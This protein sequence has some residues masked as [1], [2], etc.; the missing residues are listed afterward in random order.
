VTFLVGI[1][2][3]ALD[4]S[5]VGVLPFMV[6]G[7]TGARRARADRQPGLLAALAAGAAAAQPLA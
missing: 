1:T 5:R 3:G 7:L 2:Q 4:N 6:L